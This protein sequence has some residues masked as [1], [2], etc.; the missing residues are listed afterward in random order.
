MEELIKSL[1]IFIKYMDKD[2]ITYKFPISVGYDVIFLAGP[3]VENMSL[4]EIK[5]LHKYGWHPGDPESNEFD[6]DV[7]NLTQNE[8][9][10]IKEN[11]DDCFYMNV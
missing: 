5:E 4:D 6:G 8:W 2:D 7:E 1:Q 10:E 9:D 11:I 3:I